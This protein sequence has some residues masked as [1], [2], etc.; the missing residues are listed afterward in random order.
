MVFYFTTM[1][2]VIAKS[3][4]KNVMFTWKC[5][6]DE[7][8]YLLACQLPSKEYQHRARFIYIWGKCICDAICI[9]CAACSFLPMHKNKK[10]HKFP[11]ISIIHLLQPSPT[12]VCHVPMT[13]ILVKRMQW[14]SKHKNMG[15]ISRCYALNIYKA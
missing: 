1:I 15:K 9:S 14:K 5:A 6:V 8:C 4:L 11:Y 13:E 12:K 7:I 10:Y 3:I 2:F